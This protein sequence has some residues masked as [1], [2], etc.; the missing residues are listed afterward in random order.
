MDEESR[1]SGI[2]LSDESMCNLSTPVARKLSHKAFF[3]SP[4]SDKDLSFKSFF[5]SPDSTPKAAGF[6]KTRRTLFGHSET[7]SNDAHTF[8]HFTTP[9]CM[10]S[11]LRPNA[12]RRLSDHEDDHTPVK[13]SKKIRADVTQVRDSIKE[14]LNKQISCDDL[15]GDFS[16]GHRLET[17]MGKHQDF[18]SISPRTVADLI[19]GKINVQ[20][21]FQ[22][23]DSRYPY[24]YEG[25]HI[26]G[27]ANMHTQ[28]QINGFLKSKCNEASHRDT[29]LI[30]HCEFSSERGPKR[31]RFLRSRDRELNSEYYPS[32]CFPEIYIMNGG[33]KS[34]YQEHPHLCTPQGYTPMLKVGHREDLKKF[35]SKSRSW[36]AG[37]KPN[38]RYVR[39][40]LGKLELKF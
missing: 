18:K 39:S 28:D 40:E 26:K 19:S 24:E 7:S 33:Y 21:D 32:L 22:I 9:V 8:D 36:T 3:T 20:C 15:V 37:L 16:R 29:I 14:A 23:V 1:D 25:G 10:T 2:F 4:E 34:F 5:K 17:V 11:A 27:A 31:A 12:K 6:R 30:F 35:R 13:P 38:N